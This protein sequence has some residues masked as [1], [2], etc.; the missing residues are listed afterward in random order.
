MKRWGICMASAKDWRDPAD[1]Q[2]MELTKAK[3]PWF[4]SSHAA[5]EHSNAKISEFCMISPF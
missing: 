1:V 3:M 2:P 4:I 5:R